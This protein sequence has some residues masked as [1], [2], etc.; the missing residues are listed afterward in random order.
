[1]PATPRYDPAP[2]ARA[3]ADA[4]RSG[5]QLTE[6]PVEIRPRGLDEGYDL[7]D[8]LMR[9][10]AEPIAGWKLGVGS[11][12]ALRSTGLQRPLVGRLLASHVHGN[13]SVVRLP[14]ASAVTVE[15]EIAFVLGR[16]LSPTDWLPDP[17]DAVSA[18]HVTFELVLSRYLNR[19]AVGW[20]SFAGDSVGFEALVVGEAFAR[21]DMARV[22]QSV[23]IEADGR[24]VARAL[25]GDDLTDPVASFT[26]LIAHARERGVT[27]KRGEIATLG[28][29]GKP[30]DVQGGG[31]IVARYLDSELRVQIE[32]GQPLTR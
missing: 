26:Y 14:N 18:M 11:R 8:A 31:T 2:A 12:A 17:L 9:E 10:M 15:F 6:L 1:M 30:F 5:K 29:I 19:V 24:E 20:P 23:V 21:S 7:Q 25:S 4:W 32:P 28:A 27:L 22:A 3:L 13:G 16:D